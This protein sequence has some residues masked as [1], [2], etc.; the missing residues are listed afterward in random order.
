[1]R[2]WLRVEVPL[3]CCAARTIYSVSKRPSAMVVMKH[4]AFTRPDGVCV[5]LNSSQR[6]RLVLIT[7]FSYFGYRFGLCFGVLPGVPADYAC[8]V[9]HSCI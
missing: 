7:F 3:D 4:L 8:D 9:S 5:F 1:M 2:L 6:S